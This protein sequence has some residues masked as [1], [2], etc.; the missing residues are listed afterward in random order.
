MGELQLKKKTS[1]RELQPCE[2]A[3]I[4]GA[5]LGGYAS[6]AAVL[7]FFPDS[8]SKSTVTKLVSR[9]QQLAD[10]SGLPLSNPYLYETQPGRG[11]KEL[12]TPKQ[13][14]EIIKI[15]TSDRNHREKEAWQAI[16]DA[17]FSKI[18][19]SISISTFENIMYAA[20]YSRKKPSWKPKLTAEEEKAHFN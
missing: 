3:F 17:D 2:R 13:K 16:K 6:H 8:I 10:K 15:T 7:T 19:P 11:R 20:G 9:V 12:L 14:E 4:A 5:V 18:T 1:R